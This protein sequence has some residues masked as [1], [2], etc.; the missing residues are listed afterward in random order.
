MPLGVPD[1][2]SLS[3]G[4]A[5]EVLPLKTILAKMRPLTTR[6]SASSQVEVLITGSGLCGEFPAE[7]WAEILAGVLRVRG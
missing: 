3:A 1:P 7:G 6:K 4:S 2:S 5:N